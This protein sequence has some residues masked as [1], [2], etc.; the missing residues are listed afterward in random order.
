MDMPELTDPKFNRFGNVNTLKE[1]TALIKNN[2]IIPFVGAGMSIDIYGSW[3]SALERIVDGHIYGSAAKEVQ[4]S[5][6]S[7]HYE[8]AAEKISGLLG[9]TDF[10]DQLVTVFGASRITD[11]ILKKMPVRYLPKIFKDSLVVTT[12]FD[13]VLERVFLMEQH[14][15]EEKVVLSHLT[16]WQAE[17]SQRGSL[18]YLIKIHGCVSAPDEVVMT[19]TSYDGLYKEKSPHIS[20]LRSILGGNN[21]LFIGCGLM[22]DRTVDLLREVGLGGHYAILEMNGEAEDDAFQQRKRLMSNDLKMHC[23]WYPKGEHRCVGD[24]LEYIYADITGQLEAVETKSQ[25]FPGIE[26][27]PAH[28]QKKKQTKASQP[29]AKPLVINENYTMGKWNDRPVEWLVLDVQPDKALLIAKD[30][31]MKVAYNNKNQDITWERC[32]L[33]NELLPQLLEQIFNDTERGRVLPYKNR[34]P[35][36]AKRSIPGGNDTTDKLFLLSIDE[37]T[38]YFPYDD[39]RIARLDGKAVW[40]WLRSPG[41]SSDSAALVDTDGDVY[42]LGIDVSWSEGGVRPAFW[43]NLKS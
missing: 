2:R 19:K 27:N 18:H 6:D 13:K 30:C 28:A 3:G 34:N 16:G 39:A 9:V 41:I 7:F 1:L 20:H 35:D 36:N 32:S 40:W 37:A 25:E 8:E 26:Q 33:R 24:I 5:I 12:N 42:D 22:K 10:H 23:I 17:R 43:L 21:L 38:Q 14:S 11:V 29:T 31:L 4:S 15:F